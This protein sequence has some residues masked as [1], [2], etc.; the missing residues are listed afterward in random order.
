MAAQR[1]DALQIVMGWGL[2]RLAC[3]PDLPNGNL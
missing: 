1:C 3:A 2:G